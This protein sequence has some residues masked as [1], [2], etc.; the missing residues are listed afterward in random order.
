MSVIKQKIAPCLWFDTQA[1]EAA[2]LYTSLFKNSSIGRISRYSEVGKEFHGKEAGSVMTVEF[3]LDGQP[4]TALNGGPLFKFN[5]AI[6]LQI[7]CADQNEIDHFWN[8]LI[9]GGGEEGPCGW[10]KD[11]FGVSWQVTPEILPKMLTEGDAAQA[12]RVTQAFF[13]MKKFDVAALQR[14]YDGRAA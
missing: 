6:S 3:V 10:L 4:F 2:R 7:S 5:E 8:G 9:A 1:E 12:T 14:A 11:R 13:Q